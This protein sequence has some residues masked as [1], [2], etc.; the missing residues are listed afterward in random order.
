[1]AGAALPWRVEETCFNAF[2][3]LR[4]VLLGDWLLR[5][6]EGLSRRANSVNPLRPDCR[7]LDTAIAAAEALYR[8][9]GLPTIFRVP[10]LAAPALD[11][12]LA[13]RGYTREGES[14]V[15]Y[16][17][18]AE[19]AAAADAE[20]QLL[21]RA[22][23]DWLAAMGALQ[24]H[25]AEQRRVYRRVVR[26]IA[27]PA[28]FAGLRVDGRFVALAYGAMHDGLLCYESVI[29]DPARRRRGSARRVVAAL[30][31][32]ARDEGASGAC[33][34]VEA[35]NAP[36]LALYDGFGLKA[37]LHRYHYRRAP[38]GPA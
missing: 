8:R 9:Q 38:D 11:A 25:S 20:V 32:W 27:V 14:C 34:Q 22:G 23:P 33:L 26:A 28:A 29:T 21:P 10:T 16:G 15:L 4:Q 18:I 19:L 31:A 17:D 37:E 7:R 24:R 12:A 30:A 13:D 35:G 2:P 6:A 3:A 5:F 36:A 1:M